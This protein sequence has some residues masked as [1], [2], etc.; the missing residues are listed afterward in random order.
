MKKLLAFFSL[1]P[2]VATAQQ[3]EFGGTVGGGGFG[4]E[5]TGTPAYVIFGIETCAFCSSRAGLFGEYNHWQYGSGGYSSR[6]TSVDMLAVGLRLQGKRKVR[7]FFDVGFAGGWDR[8]EWDR[9][10]GSFGGS[11]SHGN[12]GLVLGGGI[13]MNL[14]ERWYI[15]P[16]V[17]L[18]ALWGLHAGFAGTV[19]VGYR[20]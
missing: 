14:A 5:G 1:L 4:A 12:P 20:F 15:R 3:W 8:F 19:G 6:I 13:A 2:L 17:R 9:I 10:G 11:G 16:Q 18:Y 7:G